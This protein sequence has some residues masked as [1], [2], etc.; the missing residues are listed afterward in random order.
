MGDLAVGNAGDIPIQTDHAFLYSLSQDKIL[1]DIVYPGSQTSSTTAYGVWYNGGTSYTIAGGYTTLL[2]PGKTAAEAYLVNYDS[3]DRAIHQLD[4]VRR[5]GG[6]VGPSFATHFQG[7]SSPEQ[8]VYTLSAN[9]IDANSS[10]S[11]QASLATVRRNPDGTFGPAD[12]VDLNYPGALGLRTADSVAGNQVVGIAIAD[13][14]HQP[15]AYQ[16]TVNLGFQLSN[17]IS[18][19]RGNGIGIYGASGNRIAMNN[20]GTD[21]TGTLKRGNAKNGILVTGG[22]AGNL[23]GGQATGGNDPTGGVVRPPAPGQPDLGQ[24]RQRRA[25]HRRGH[26]EHAERQLRRHAASGDSALG[27]RQ[28]GV[29]V[30]KADGNQLIGCTMQDQPFVYYNVLSGNGGNGLRI[31]NS[32]DTTVQANFMGV[33]ANNATVVANRGDGL[34]VS[35]SSRETQVGGVIPLGNVISGNDGNGIDVTRHGQRIH[36]VQYLRRDLRLRGRGPEQEGWHPGHVQ[37]RQ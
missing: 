35:G 4:V 16:A 27:N 23:I 8:G 9:T 20:I 17:V 12:W 3:V 14:G 37:R 15:I 6:L 29:A 36:V 26:R 25:H 13:P 11:L 7:I 10:T 18:G 21:A 24:P 31:T 19:N 1:T 2:S 28:D 22:A 30:V 34:M 32:N 33:G 5:P